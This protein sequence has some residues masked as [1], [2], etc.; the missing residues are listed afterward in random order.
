MCVW[1]NTTFL[2]HTPT[3]TIITKVAW[4]ERQR[5]EEGNE[6]RERGQK[7]RHPSSLVTCQFFIPLLLLTYLII[8]LL[9]LMTRAYYIIPTPS[10]SPHICSNYYQRRL[11]TLFQFVD[12]RGGGGSGGILQRYVQHRNLTGLRCSNA[13][14]YCL[15]SRIKH[16]PTQFI[17][18]AKVGLS[19]P[20][21]K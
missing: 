6:E 13:T 16:Q 17:F 21:E 18:L 9:S 11:H 3:G 20:M 14:T 19:H 8:L 12:S 15:V 4:R 5:R 1:G 2:V 7:N 10:Y